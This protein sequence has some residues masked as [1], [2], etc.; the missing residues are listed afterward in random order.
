MV[1][2][3]LVSFVT[4]SFF[5]SN[6]SNSE[7]LDSEPRAQVISQLQPYT[8]GFIHQ[9]RNHIHA[10]KSNLLADYLRQANF[11]QICKTVSSF[12]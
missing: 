8:D 7:N 1:V 3:E 6:L 10:R 11:Y 4:V 5:L 2:A 9:L 12:S